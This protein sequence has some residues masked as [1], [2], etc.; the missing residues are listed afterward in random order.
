M[1]L[2]NVSN[3]TNVSFLY[4]SIMDDVVVI[5]FIINSISH[6]GSAYQT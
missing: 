5:H 6:Y 2:N 4:F 3:T 1:I